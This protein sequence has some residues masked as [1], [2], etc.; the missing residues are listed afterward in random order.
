ME[1]TAFLSSVC[2]VTAEKAVI[3]LTQRLYFR[4][5][6]SKDSRKSRYPIAC[7]PRKFSNLKAQKRRFQHSQADSCV[8]DVAKI[9]HCFLPNLGKNRDRGVEGRGGEGGAGGTCPPQYF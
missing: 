2:S 4:R 5:Y 6:I 1:I 9:D 7:S 8:K 3:Q